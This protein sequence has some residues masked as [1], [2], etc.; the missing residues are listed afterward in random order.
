MWSFKHNLEKCV[1]WI[2]ILKPLQVKKF[3]MNSSISIRIWRRRYNMLNWKHYSRRMFTKRKTTLNTYTRHDYFYIARHWLSCE[4]SIKLQLFFIRT[5]FFRWTNSQVRYS[6]LWE[7]VWLEKCYSDT[8]PSEQLVNK[9]FAEFKRGRT[10]TDEVDVVTTEYI[11]NVHK[12]VLTNRSVKLEVKAVFKMRATFANSKPKQ[13]HVKG[14]WSCFG[15][16]VSWRTSFKA[17]KNARVSC[18]CSL[19]FLK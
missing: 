5:K 3:I 11:K 6:L 16:I 14:V 1:L 8:A 19:N 2:H 15:E 4:I 13:Q 10:S 12:I 7:K 18:F 17:I 9:W